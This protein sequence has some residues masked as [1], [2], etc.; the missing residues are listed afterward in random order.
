MQKYEIF[1]IMLFFFRTGDE[2][3]VDHAMHVG[4]DDGF[5]AKCEVVYDF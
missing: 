4:L 3:V 5:E 1:L 2:L